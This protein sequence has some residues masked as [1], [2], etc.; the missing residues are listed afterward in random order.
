MYGYAAAFCVIKRKELKRVKYFFIYKLAKWK[1]YRRY[2]WV[3]NEQKVIKAQKK[4]VKF[5]KNIQ[6]LAKNVKNN[7]IRLVEIL[8]ATLKL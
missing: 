3:Y 7:F 4:N 2:F 1:N 6:W 8:N 5:V